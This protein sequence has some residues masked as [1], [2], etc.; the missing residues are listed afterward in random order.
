[1]ASGAAKYPTVTE[2]DKIT[3]LSDGGWTCNRHMWWH[4]PNCLASWPIDEAYDMAKRDEAKGMR[5]SPEE[6]RKY[7]D[8]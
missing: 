2:N 7:L 8:E 3:Y 6:V 5:M 1:M 4:P